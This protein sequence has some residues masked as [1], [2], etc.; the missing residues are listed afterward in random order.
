TARVFVVVTL[1]GSVAHRVA[2]AD[3]IGAVKAGDVVLARTAISE[4]ANPNE[5]E[6]DG[7]T[8]LHWAAQRDDLAAADLLLRAGANAKASNRYGVTPIHLAATNGSAPM[9]E[10]LLQAGADVN[11]TLPQG[12]TA[13]MRG[14]RS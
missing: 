12:E 2:A 4:H 11:A 6:A 8:A 13:L 5:T 7:T 3:L 14:A 9:I 10:R 1:M